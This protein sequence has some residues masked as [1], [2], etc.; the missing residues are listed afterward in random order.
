MAA[1]H[2][3]ASVVWTL[4]VIVNTVM[5]PQKNSFENKNDIDL[6]F[7][8]HRDLPLWRKRNASQNVGEKT[9]ANAQCSISLHAREE[10]FVR[11]NNSQYA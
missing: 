11:H 10:G 1:D 4:S 6:K 2:R 5:L 7:S 8:V 3:N 9:H